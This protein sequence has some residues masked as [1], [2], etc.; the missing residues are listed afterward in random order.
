MNRPLIY[1]FAF[2][3]SDWK[4]NPRRGQFVKLILENR[5]LIKTLNFPTQTMD[6]RIAAKNVAES[7]LADIAAGP[8]P[9]ADEPDAAA[10]A[11]PVPSIRAGEPTFMDVFFAW[12]K[13]RLLYNGLLILAVSAILLNAGHNVLVVGMVFVEPAIYA[14]LFFCAGPVVEGYLSWLGFRHPACR[15]YIFTVGLFFSFVTAV[16]ATQELLRKL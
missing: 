2:G 14:N 15:W 9:D 4:Q 8:P 1:P 3:K 13:L 7:P 12:E 11:L 10:P 6:E 16:E 5:R